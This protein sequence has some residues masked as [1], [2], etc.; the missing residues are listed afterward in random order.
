MKAVPPSRRAEALLAG[1][2]KFG[3]RPGLERMREILHALGDPQRRLKV[4]HVAGTNGKGS[5]SALLSSVL[6]EAGYRVG[7][8][9]SPH[10]LHYRERFWVD[11]SFIPEAD[12]EEV[13]LRVGDLAAEVEA[14]FPDLG[15]STEFELLTAAA[16]SWFE[17]AAC[18]LAIVEVGLGGRL[19]ATNCFE[20]PEATVITSIDFDHTAIL[21]ETLE[22][23]AREKAGIL[24]ANVPVITATSG[25]AL[26]AIRL[27]AE[28]LGAPLIPVAGE[29]E[30]PIALSGPY[31][32]RNAALVE[33]VVAS[34]RD[35]GWMISEEA[36][37]RGFAKASW[38]GRMEAWRDG[39]GGDWLA[40]GA[41]NPAGIDALCEALRHD[42][43]GVRWT[44][45]FGALTDRDARGMLEQLLPF[46]R[47]LLLVAPPSPRALDPH[48]LAAGLR[49]P[50]SRIAQSVVEAVAEARRMPGP[51]AVFGSLYLVGAVKEALGWVPEP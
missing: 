43:P 14:R 9:T 49:H 17:E 33:S 11:G 42:H 47:S 8:Y 51:Y 28:A 2:L 13:L 29:S 12:F 24:R 15:P 45:I 20:K 26:E 44:L 48:H 22:A 46:A 38:P 10:L 30:R 39:E 50:D 7:R 16:F 41:H 6:R 1:A 19:D 21:G 34:L 23:I 35:S 31:Q 5:T 37:S 32:R 40:D 27:A 18:D 25:L 4:I 36:V 3:I